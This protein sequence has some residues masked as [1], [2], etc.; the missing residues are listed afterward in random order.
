MSM[1]FLEELEIA[2]M[3]GDG[4]MGTEILKAGVPPDTCFEEL[5]VSNPDLIAG[6]HENYIRAGARIIRTN[7]FLANAARLARSGF[8]KRVN[9]INWSAARLARQCARGKNVY[10]AGSVG[11]LSLTAKETGSQGVKREALFREQIG[12]LLDG[13]AQ[14]IF[15]ETFTDPDEL[16]IALHIKHSLHHCPVV[17]SLACLPDGR[18]PSGMM[19][20][21]AFDKL[22]DQGA[23][24]VGVNC[25]N[26][27]DAMPSLCEQ[28]PGI[29]STFPNA[30][31]PEKRADGSLYYSLSPAKFAAVTCGL[32][33]FGVRLI[34]GCCGVG[35]AHIEALAVALK[36]QGG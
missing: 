15:L 33:K 19:L 28:V 6:I 4:A 16:A 29:Q 22:R 1:D 34:G 18:L 32:A 31:M 27:P 30:G 25:V 21:S 12:A 23:D 24:L 20:E 2:P 9:E 14:L 36:N 26:G 5:S 3:T 35:P 11:P 8:E 10:V 7:S 13:G 17:C